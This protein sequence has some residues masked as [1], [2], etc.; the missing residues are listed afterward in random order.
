MFA[1][2]TTGIGFLAAVHDLEGWTPMLGGAIIGWGIA[3]MHYTG[4]MALKLRGRF[5]WSPDFVLSWSNEQ[6]TCTA[7]VGAADLV[8]FP[9]GWRSAIQS[10]VRVESAC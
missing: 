4:M 9:A 6:K 5:T 3:A 1:T 7:S 8:A 10:A 2:L